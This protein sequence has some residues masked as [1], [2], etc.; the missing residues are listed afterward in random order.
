MFKHLR[1]GKQIEIKLRVKDCY[2]YTC[3]RE[4]HH[5]G[6]MSHRAM[7][8]RK[9]EECKIMYSDGRTFT[10]KFARPTP[11][12]VDKAGV[13]RVDR[14]VFIDGV[15]AQCGTTIASLTTNA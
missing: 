4:I 3:A 11:R 8:R 7:H 6:I 5:L 12:A 14:H 1:L 10:H 2:C 15:C 13:C 9:N